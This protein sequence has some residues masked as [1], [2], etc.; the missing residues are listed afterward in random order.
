MRM[1]RPGSP[2]LLASSLLILAAIG[3][4]VGI[5][6]V[7][8]AGEKPDWQLD[9][10]KYR[11]PVLVYNA[12]TMDKTGLIVT[13]QDFPF[14]TL[15]NDG[16]L[17][18]DAHDLRLVDE[19]GSA[20]TPLRP[21]F[22]LNDTGKARLTFF[23][24]EVGRSE[25]KFFWLY[26]GNPT[27]PA[28][29]AL[30]PE[31]T[32]E[33]IENVGASYGA[34]ETPQPVA[35]AEDAGAQLRWIAPYHLTEV[36]KGKLEGAAA[37]AKLT[38]PA[39]EQVSGSA[40]VAFRDDARG[41]IALEIDAEAGDANCW[42]RYCPS[43]LNKAT[44][45]KLGI[46]VKQGDKVL[47]EKNLDLRQARDEEPGPD[48]GMGEM[49]PPAVDDDTRQ[50]LERTGYRWLPLRAVLAAGKATVTITGEK[51]LAGVDCVLMTRDV[52]YLPDVRDFQNR[53]WVRWRYLG[54]AG[55]RFFTYV[56]NQINYT[57]KGR[58]MR[59]TGDVG[60]YG[61]RPVLK[62]PLEKL[63]SDFIPAG[64]FSNWVLLP[65]STFDTWYS[66]YNIT[67]PDGQR[68]DYANTRLE[69]QFATRPSTTHLFHIT[70]NESA[71]TGPIAHVRMPTDLSWEGVNRI[72]S[73]G[74][75]AQRRLALVKN[76]KL[77]PP[78]RLTHVRVG[79]WAFTGSPDSG[80]ER[81]ENEFGIQSNLGF[82]M[83][84]SG[85]PDTLFEKLAREHG[86]IDTNSI[87]WPCGTQLAPGTWK[88]ETVDGWLEKNVTQPYVGWAAA[89]KKDSP[90]A[91]SIT[92]RFNM[93]DEIGPAVDAKTIQVSPAMMAH[94]HDFLQKQSL[95]PQTFG[96][97]SWDDV[98][99]IDDRR[100]L[101]QAGPP[102]R[103]GDEIELPPDDPDLAVKNP[104]LAEEGPK[105]PPDKSLA[106][107]K[108]F[109]YTRRY[110]DFYTGCY[111]KRGTDVLLKEFPKARIISPNYQAGPMQIAFLGNNNDTDKGQLDIFHLSRTHSFV[112]LQVEDWVGGNDYGI[113]RE[114]LGT[115]IMRSAARKHKDALCALQ[116]GGE[117]IKHEMFAFLMHGAK[118][119]DSYLYG[120]L[121]NIGPAWGDLPESNASVARFTREIKPFDEAI[122]AGDLRPRKAALLVA[123]TSEFMQQ[124]GVGHCNLRQN[125]YIALE[126]SYLPVDV[127]CEQEI[128]ED[129]ILKNYSLLY[130]TD[131]QTTTAV[132]KKI[133]EWVK[134]GGRLWAGAGALNWDEFNQPSPV[135]NEVL[136]VAKR[137]VVDHE[138][139]A[140]APTTTLTAEAPQFGGK[141]TLPVYGETLE[142][143]PT[144]AKVLG[145]YADGKPA[146][147][148]NSYGKGEALLVGALVGTSY[149]QAHF[150]T[151][152]LDPAWKFEM[153]AEAL[154]L[155]GGLAESAKIVKPVM[156]SVPGIY[157]AVWDTPQGTLVFLNN[158]TYSALWNVKD[159]RPAP[160]VTIRMRVPGPVKTVTSKTGEVKFTQ[161]GNEVTVQLALPDTDILLL[162]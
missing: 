116:V 132:Q 114:C 56:D 111:Y 107:A 3:I 37:I 150:T 99:P 49:M 86:L 80:M 5:F 123:Y 97:D 19:N 76:M 53:V 64:E 34:E 11:R 135:L 61:L 88:G 101:G 16:K 75:W 62:P 138:T 48:D 159:R 32:L 31:D 81:I 104:G 2:V 145:S 133:A 136:G 139:K 45:G 14:L 146:V 18:G 95:T 68:Y 154:R 124:R 128:V 89:Y 30:D 38:G 129:D 131:P 118:D 22:L 50:E 93:M 4:V 120:P 130:I 6:P 84:F 17:A 42:V 137:T 121:Q 149:Y 102:K 151:N 98:N 71:D 1:F 134:T 156:L 91:A 41:N 69:M 112:G 142:I 9:G 33:L 70:K 153:G 52:K 158:A 51:T 55:S 110:I 10:W 24:K 67:V 140:G 83:L 43:T 39:G 27:A 103:P 60:A 78:P 100:I 73:F 12:S 82:N 35:R 125:T 26:Y 28:P 29:P 119:L 162:K 77:G 21:D 36:E 157:T 20:A 15:I 108:L 109:Y 63:E 72:E 141:V 58:I 40:L 105:Y 87:A 161:Q 106:A 127:V 92:T 152:I 13:L 74:E 117:S 143:Q 66:E 47:A 57:N 148:L 44:H 94:F 96:M 113:G 155:L 144:T 8:A 90:F 160:Q 46:V 54:P 23:V 7:R 122:G 25:R 147:T 65:T 85:L 126:H 79:D 115:E 59:P